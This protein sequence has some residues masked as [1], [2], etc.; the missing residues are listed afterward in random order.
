MQSVDRIVTILALLADSSKGLGITDL[1]EACELPKSTLHRILT[2]LVMHDFAV[3]DPHTK[4]YRLGSAMLRMGARFL[5]QNDVRAIA[6]PYLEQAEKELRETVYLCILQG[7]RVICVDAVSTSRDLN[8][9]VSVGK[10]MPFNISAA[11]KAILAYQ[12]ADFI[13]NVL[14][15][16]K[17]AFKTANSITD[18]ERLEK[19]LASI[20]ILG[21]SICEEEM[22][23]GAT[24]V[25]APLWD[26]RGQVTASVAVIGP[27]VRLQGSY[28]Q[29]VVDV[30]LATAQVISRQ[31]GMT[32]NY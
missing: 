19:H 25:A 3:Q 12:P 4:K 32:Q 1:Y 18:P 28:R 24:A 6:R 29:G 26:W 14:G 21:Y 9:F 15:S 7:E 10:E 5:S 11:A 16:D 23:E 13:A 2:S 31:W 20:R 27:A 8:Y 30:I 22:E 17:I